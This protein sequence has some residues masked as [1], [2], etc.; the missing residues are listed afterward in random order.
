MTWYACQVVRSPV[1]IIFPDWRGNQIF[2]KFPKG[3][4]IPVLF[5]LGMSP[6]ILDN[7]SAILISKLEKLTMFPTIQ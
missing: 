4:H 2:Y 6:V 7:G 5:C 3:G 1:L